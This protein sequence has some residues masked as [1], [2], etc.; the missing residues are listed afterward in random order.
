VTTVFVVGQHGSVGVGHPIVTVAVSNLI[1]MGTGP[2]PPGGGNIGQ[3]YL[4]PVWVDVTTAQVC[5]E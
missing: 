1:H 4:P 5:E 3:L 2:Q